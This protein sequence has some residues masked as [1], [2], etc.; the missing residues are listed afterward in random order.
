MKTPALKLTLEQ[1]R[2]FRARRAH[3]AGPGEADLVSCARQLL[4]AQAQ[5]DSCAYWALAMRTQGNPTAAEVAAQIFEGDHALVRTWGQRDTLHLYDARDWPIII[6]ARNSWPRSGRRDGH[7]PEESVDKIEQ[8]FAQAPAPLRTS[9][10]YPHLP[11]DFI[12]SVKDHE[13]ATGPN[14]PTRFAANRHIRQLALRGDIT[15][16]PRVGSENSYAHRSLWHPELPWPELT[17]EDACISATRRYLAAFGPSSAA[18][19]AHYMGARISDVKKWLP[20]MQAELIEVKA[21]DKAGLWALS[22]DLDDLTIP[23][24]HWPARLLPGYDT[25]LMT[26]KDKRIILPDAAEEKLVWRKAAVVMPVVLHQGQI[27]ATWA[28]KQTKTKLN[29]EITPMSAW[30]ASII[31]DVESDALRFA[32]HLSVSLEQVQVVSR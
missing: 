6:A 14:G 13:G 11:A 28:H 3:L 25:M 5:V 2:Q 7:P 26:H 19:I 29:V 8:V 1:I 16:G 30:D 4:G 23:L 17:P 9:E 15:F 22:E 21:E 24:E 31:P 12:E 27:V 20:K 32:E 10:I 18:D